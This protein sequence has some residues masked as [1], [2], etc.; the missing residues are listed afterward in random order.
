MA[1]ERADS[2]RK[3]RKCSEAVTGRMQSECFGA[4]DDGNDDD[5]DDGDEEASKRILT[6][7]GITPD[8]SFR[9]H[10]GRKRSRKGPHGYRMSSCAERHRR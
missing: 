9:V 2:G 6:L 7:P 3:R 8:G 1:E 5:D 4:K 10:G